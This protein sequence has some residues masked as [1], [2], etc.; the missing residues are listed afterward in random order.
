MNKYEALCEF[1]NSFGIP[2]YEEFSVDENAEMPY[3]KY[4]VV[5]SG[6]DSENTA[7]S[8]QI[9]YKSDSLTKI[10]AM[11]DKLSDALRD[12]IKL[13]CDEGYIILYRGE[14]FAQNVVSGDKSVKC[15]YVNITADFITL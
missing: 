1:Y 10:D 13:K 2:A 6:F 3:I 9:L 7:L 8:L 4:E 14:P 12:G 11:T 15:K 5:T